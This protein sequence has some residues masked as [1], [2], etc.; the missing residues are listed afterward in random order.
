MLARTAEAITVGEVLR[1]IEGS[2]T[3]GARARKRVETPF[4]AMWND[5]ERSVSAVLDHTSFADLARTW[6]DRQSKYVP[7]WEI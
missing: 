5:V 4:S 6:K 3:A 2:R 7:N 1:H